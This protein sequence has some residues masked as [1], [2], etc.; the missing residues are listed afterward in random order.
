MI[1]TIKSQ[2]TNRDDDSEKMRESTEEIFYQLTS[3]ENHN[4]LFVNSMSTLLF[5][6]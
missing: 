3:T 5:T 6:E 2:L 4:Y 1:A